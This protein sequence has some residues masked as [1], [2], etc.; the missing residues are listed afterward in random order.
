MLTRDL[1]NFVGGYLKFSVKSPVDLLVGIRSGD[2][3]ESQKDSKM[4]LS[5]YSNFLPDNNWHEMTIPLKDFNPSSP[6]F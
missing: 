5:E 1:S 2:M 6:L 3:L 4:L